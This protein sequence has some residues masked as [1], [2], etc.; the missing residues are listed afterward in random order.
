MSYPQM[1]DMT[2]AQTKTSSNR[3]SV[4]R[5]TTT[6]RTEPSYLLGW[7]CLAKFFE[8][9]GCSRQ[10][11]WDFGKVWRFFVSQ[12]QIGKL[13]HPE[14]Y[15]QFFFG[16]QLQIQLRKRWMR[17]V[18]RRLSPPR[19]SSFHCFLLPSLPTSHRYSWCLRNVS[20]AAGR[21][22]AWGEMGKYICKT[23]FL[24]IYQN[25]IAI[26]SGMHYLILQLAMDLF[27]YQSK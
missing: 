10:L 17:H 13:F 12:R 15:T 21:S 16:R 1:R 11:S 2:E 14:F 18:K 8:S 22:F 9:R 25:M 5:F 6:A 20:Y 24:H 7:S 26:L 23:Q 3:G 19:S 4:K 27:N